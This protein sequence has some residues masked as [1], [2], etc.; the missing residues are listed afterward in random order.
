MSIH[1]N[2]FDAAE[3]LDGVS[4]YADATGKRL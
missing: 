4:F 1:L 2:A 3:T